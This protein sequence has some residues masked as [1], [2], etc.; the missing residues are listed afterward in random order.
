MP[1]QQ[2]TNV[3]PS[4]QQDDTSIYESLSECYSGYS[5]AVSDFVSKPKTASG[6]SPS[7][8]AYESDR[9]LSTSSAAN[10]H[11]QLVHEF[12]YPSPPPPVPDRSLKPSRLRP[13]PPIKPRKKKTKTAEIDVSSQ[14]A[15][16][17]TIVSS[18]S[19]T[20][21]SVRSMSSRHY[22]GSLPIEHIN[23]SNRARFVTF[24][25]C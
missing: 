3:L 7:D 5:S 16:A 8:E 4:V 24:I 13:A 15:F 6:P 1:Q 21:S 17:R 23:A 22:C 14:I 2:Y 18:A 19:E 9:T 25:V 11:P 10:V 12:E 20:S